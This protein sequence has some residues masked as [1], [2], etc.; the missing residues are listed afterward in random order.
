MITHLKYASLPCM[1]LP[2]ALKFWTERVG[3]IHNRDLAGENWA[4]LR[5]A[6]SETVVV[7]WQ[8]P[9]PAT[10]GVTAAFACDDLHATQ[11]QLKSRGVDVTEVRREGA[12]EFAV[13][14][15]PDG[16]QYVLGSR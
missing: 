14:K 5:I 4:E 11:K 10:V 1:N 2:V 12:N 15:D 7:L 13:F 16:N 6:N 9:A 8:R 3:F